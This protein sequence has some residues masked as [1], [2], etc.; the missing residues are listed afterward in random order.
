[1]PEIIVDE[2]KFLSIFSAIARHNAGNYHKA[3]ELNKTIKNFCEIARQIDQ[4]KK[5][6]A[7]WLSHKKTP[8]AVIA[9]NELNKNKLLPLIENS[10]SEAFNLFVEI[11]SFVYGDGTLKKDLS[12]I[13]LFG[14]EADLSNLQD[15]IKNSAG[16]P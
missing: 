11:F 5:T 1:M 6:V 10:D 14:Q 4:P 9:I 7:D 2:D 16:S 12:G 3:L 15:K 13:D 8:H